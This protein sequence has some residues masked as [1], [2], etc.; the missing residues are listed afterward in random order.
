MKMI[1]VEIYSK[2]GCCLCEEMKEVLLRVQ[3]DISFSIQEIDIE[4]SPALYEAYKERIPLVIINGQ[5]AF[6][7][8]MTDGE[9]RRRLAREDSHGTSA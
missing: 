9:L 5:P 6:K 8:H 4:S 2:R 3:R 7:F 1:R